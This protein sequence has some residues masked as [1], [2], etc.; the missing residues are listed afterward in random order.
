MEKINSSKIIER[1]RVCRHY[2][3]VGMDMAGQ[4]VSEECTADISAGESQ[5]I[6]VMGYLNTSTGFFRAKHMN[7]PLACP[8]RLE[9]ILE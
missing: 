2:F 1:C 6:V 3:T 5:F 9:Y 7:V 4:E 8:Y